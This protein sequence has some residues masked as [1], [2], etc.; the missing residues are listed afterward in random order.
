ML[1]I[2]LIICGATVATNNTNLALIFGSDCNPLIQCNEHYSV[3]SFAKVNWFEAHHICNSV[4][5]VL[6]T[7]NNPDQH[8][9]MLQRVNRSN[10]VLGDKRFWLGA[11][12]LVEGNS[13]WT[14][15]SSGLPMTYGLWGKKEPRSD[16]NG[17][18]ACLVLGLDTMW[19]SAACNLKFNFI[20]ENI[21]L[22][23]GTNINNQIYV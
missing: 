2:L 3:A 21:C 9:L 4:G 17:A 12:N 23:N 16:R 18:D 5:A 13:S 22:L 10:S 8:L 19:H 11:T 6:A 20:C 7:V 14:W 15:L 1:F